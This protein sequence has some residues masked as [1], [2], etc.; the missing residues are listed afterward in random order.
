MRAAF[1]GVVAVTTMAVDAQAA[2]VYENFDAVIP[3]AVPVGWS[4]SGG[5]TTVGSDASSQPNRA[6]CPE[7]ATTSNSLLNSPTFVVE[8]PFQVRFQHRF[9]TEE[10]YD[11]GIL[12][13]SYDGGPFVDV[14]AA[15]GS[16]VEGGYTE[17][18]VTAGSNPLAGKR[19]WTGSSGGFIRTVV[20]L[21]APAGGEVRLAFHF[22]TDG[23]QGG[24]GW[25]IDDVQVFDTCRLTCPA[26]MTIEAEASV[27]GAVATFARADTTNCGAVLMYPPSGS[28]FDV[29]ETTVAA[30][31]E[32][33][34]FCETTV[35]V[36][37]NQPPTII[38]PDTIVIEAASRACAAPALFVPPSG[39]DNCT[40]TSECSVIPGQSLPPGDTVVTCTVTDGG[41]R[42]ASCDFVITVAVPE[43]EAGGVCEDKQDGGGGCASASDVSPV[44]VLLAALAIYCRI[45]RA[46]RSPKGN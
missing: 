32:A 31:S 5:F 6:F 23:G 44:L 40:S 4:A 28:F 29:G 38:C 34:P 18:L 11:G 19:A 10:K 36:A 16:F 22:G 37:D 15:G 26:P 17:K 2:D 45:S 13:V 12:E 8:N 46:D 43:G 1:I 24:N 27:C 33:G 35:T 25:S 20:N 7:P 21:P 42:S 3:P 14:L 41:L 39:L 9:D 30:V